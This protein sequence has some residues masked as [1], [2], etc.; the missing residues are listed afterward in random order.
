M[1]KLTTHLSS[2]ETIF[3]NEVTTK[4]DL[5]N[6]LFLTLPFYSVKNTGLALPYFFDHCEKGI[7]NHQTPDEIIESFFTQQKGLT[8]QQ[9]T[10]DLLFRFI[11]YI[12][13]QVVLFDAVEDAAFSKI[14]VQEEATSL[15]T[16]MNKALEDEDLYKK[17]QDCLSEFKLRLVLT[18]HPTQFYP[19]PVLGIMTDLTDAIKVNDVNA[20]NLLLQQLGK[21]PFFKKK[22]PTPVDEAIS[23]TWYLE[24]IL[25]QTASDVHR[26]LESV[27]NLNLDN[28]SLIE[29]G[30]WPG[31]DRD[32]NPFVTA[33]TTEQVSSFLRKALFRC[34]YR[35]F[36]NMKRRVTFNG[37]EKY[38]DILETIIYDNAF[39]INVNVYDNK[40]ELLDSL[41]N[42]KR[43]LTDYHDSL[44]V[45]IVDDMIWKVKLFG[46]HFA[47]LDIRQDSRI[48]R[49]L[50]EE[51]MSNPEIKGSISEN[52]MNLSETEK[53][54]SIPLNAAELINYNKFT[55]LSKDS[56]DVI[57]LIKDLQKNNGKRA[58]HRFIISNCQKASDILQ[59]MQLF[60]WSGWKMDELD[61][62][63][64][65][66]FE[67]IDDLKAAEEVMQSLYSHPI[68]AKHLERRKNRQVIMLGFSDSTK[69]GGYLMA[70]WSLYYAKY[71]LTSVSR[72]NG[73]DLAFFDGR[74]GPPARGG[75]KTHKFYASF[76]KDVANK[77]IQITVQGQ[78][79]SSH[80]GT[81]ETSINN[82]EQLIHAGITSA[83]YKQKEN[84][85]DEKEKSLLSTMAD[86]SYHAFIDLRTNPLFLKFMEVQSPLKMLSQIN[87]SS[88]PVK[89]NSD[90]ELKLEDLRAISFVTSWSQL[91]QNIPGFFGVGAALAKMKEDG[92]WLNL[93]NLYKDSGFYKTIIDNC[94]MSMKKADFRLT[95][96][97]A[98]DETFGEFWKMLHA[99]YQLTKKLLLDLSDTKVLME[100]YP[101]EA[102]SIDVREKITLPLVIIQRYAIIKSLD[103]NL[104]ASQKEVYDKLILRTLYG[105]V[106]AARNS[107]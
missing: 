81:F 22:K 51:C 40:E 43:V 36:K 86:I 67:T 18:A 50:F 47:S 26:N 56:L 7:E 28:H 45:D 29:L 59:L 70:N 74:G 39:R 100:K 96:Y 24:N 21:T 75:G 85:L 76:G 3:K 2:K 32:G 58:C 104:K 38:M 93:K 82:L 68:Y 99:E 107:A 23:L 41:R 95:A 89:R 106:N 30:F 66:L 10:T 17:I 8:K 65:P 72:K 61:I 91:K 27:F 103:K 1:S 42:I 14:S 105:I 80:Y 49:S 35:D 90:S 83:L 15:R 19:G 12:E 5:Y 31:G 37:V 13:R 94:M 73:I 25:Y 62:D 63:F 92:E 55:D 71:T 20:I 69:D 64:V 79:I 60:L 98:D 101:T 84:T 78:T 11:Q 88:R 53:I 4:F 34:Y 16:L 87:I 48:L 57:R 46:C 77:Q 44:F 102:Q 97:L 52:Y 54:D 33:E 6:S 9:D